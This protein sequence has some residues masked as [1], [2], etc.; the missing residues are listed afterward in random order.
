MAK[1]ITYLIAGLLII[2]GI[3]HSGYSQILFPG[4]TNH[5]WYF[6][7]SVFSISFNKG[8]PA[9]AYLDSVMVTPYSPFGNGVATD[10]VTGELLFYT[11]G[12][13]VYDASHRAMPGAVSR[14]AVAANQGIALS[15]VPG[16]PDQYYIFAINGSG[17]VDFSV[18][19]MQFS[20]NPPAQFGGANLGDVS[21]WRQDMPGN[22]GNNVSEAMMVVPK[23]NL[24]AGYWLITQE[25]NSTIYKV[26]DIGPGGIGTET[27]VNLLS[28]GAVPLTASHFGISPS[29]QIAVAPKEANK[30]IHLLDFD[31]S[32]GSITF[33][34]L[35]L[36]SAT[37]DV[38]AS[39]AIY[40]VE[41][42]VSNF[43]AS[44]TGST[45][46]Q[47]GLFAYD[48]LNPGTTAKQIFPGTIFRSYGL[49]YG[50]DSKI[51]HLYQESS[52]GPLI[53]GRIENPADQVDSLVYTERLY[54]LRN[55]GALQFPAVLPPK[56]ITIPMPTIMSL[57]TCVSDTIWFFPDM[58]PFTDQFQWNFMDTN[59]PAD[60]SAVS[61]GYNY[62]S[63]GGYNVTVTTSVAGNS[64]TG[65]LSIN[66]T[67]TQLQIDLGMDTV[68][69]PND[70][71]LLAI[72][73]QV[74]PQL[75]NVVWSN[76]ET[77]VSSIFVTEGGNYWV[78]G[79][80]S[81]TGCNIN[82]AI[83]VD[84]YGLNI[85][86][87]A[88]WYF[89]NL[90]GLDFN[91]QPPVPLDDGAMTAPEGCA[92]YSDRNGDILFYTDGQTVYNN[93]HQVMPNG[94]NLAAD[95]GAAQSTLIVQFPS[96]ETLYYIFS[97]T[98]TNPLVTCDVFQLSYSVVDLKVAAGG[99]VVIKNKPLFKNSTE[100]ITAV[101]FGN[102]LWLVAHEFG[103]NT[104]RAY[105]VTEFGI[106]AP[107]LSSVGSIHSKHDGT[108]GDG[109]MKLSTDGTRIAVAL[110]STGSNVV[111]LFDFDAS[112][113]IVS[114]ALQLDLNDTSGK[115]YGVE[116]SPNSNWLYATLSNFE[117]GAQ[118]KIYQWHVDSTTLA[119]NVTDTDYIKSSRAIISSGTT[120]EAL[121]A[122]QI[123]PNNAMYVAIN[124]QSFLG[125]INNPDGLQDGT[126]NAFADLTSGQSLAGGTSSALGLPN[127]V[128]NLSTQLP[129]PEIFIPATACAGD[130][131][132]FSATA[133]SIIDE[134]AWSIFDSSGG[135]VGTSTNQGDTITLVIPDTYI[136]SVRIFNRCLDPI[137]FL[138]DS[139][140][141]FPIPLDPFGLNAV[142]ICD[143]VITLTPYNNDQHTE[144]DYL[145]STG[146]T[147]QDIIVSAIGTYS[148]VITNPVAG[149]TN[150]F[151]VFV[152]PPFTV[153][154]G[155]DQ[156]ICDGT[157][158]TLDSQANADNYIWELTVGGTL[159][160]ITGFE[161][162]RFLPLNQLGPPNNPALLPGQ[163]NT[164]TVG[165]VDP[166][167]P[168][169][170]VRDTVE[171][172]INTLP[173]VNVTV[174]DVDTCGV[175]NGKMDIEGSA[176]EDVTYIVTSGTILITNL[177][178][179]GTGPVTIAGLASGVY[180]VTITSS[181]TGCTDS[182]NGIAI[183]E[184]ATF[185]ID[186]T[187]TTNDGCDPLFP[188]G[189]ITF[190][191][192]INAFPLTYT[193]R[194]Q[195]T[196]IAVP[197]H[198][199]VNVPAADDS[200]NFTL[201]NIPTGTYSLDINTA[202]CSAFATDIIVNKLPI[203]D[204]DGPAIVTACDTQVLLSNFFTTT[205]P[206][207]VIE[208]SPDGSAG[209]YQD[210]V[211]VP[212]TT[213]G[214]TDIFIRATNDPLVSCD[215]I[216][217]TQVVLTPQ[218]T[219][220]VVATEDC[221]GFVRLTANPDSYPGASYLY[222][223]FGGGQPTSISAQQSVDIFSNGTDYRVVVSHAVN[224][225]CNVTSAFQT[226]VIPIPFTVQLN[227]TS[228]CTDAEFTVTA[229][230]FRD[231]LTYKWFINGVEQGESLNQ[232]VRE[233]LPGLYRVEASDDKGCTQSD[234]LEII[235]NDP[236][237]SEILPLYTVCFQEVGSLTIDPEA[238]YLSY[239]WI[240]RET[241]LVIDTSP[242]FT[243]DQPGKFQANLVNGFQC[244][245]SDAFDVIEDC[246]AKIIAPNAFHPGSSIE[247]NQTFHL[248]TEF[249]DEFEIFV[250]NRWGELIFHSS[251]KDFNWDG[252]LNG[253]L[254]PVGSYTW[255]VKYTKEFGGKGETLSQFGGITLVQ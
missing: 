239:T 108:M 40:D 115:V 102:I 172:T 17:D 179:A 48:L 134:F 168:V 156:T 180:S 213:L 209:S 246:E 190:V 152:G 25:A 166:V 34:S 22:T 85:T 107:V 153:D 35:I 66:I 76:G 88:I 121:G 18:V 215:S 167:N 51:Y 183:N 77:N 45:I 149:C 250:Y 164:I 83:Q 8:T 26:I 133:T 205:T 202:G 203:T 230:T 243:T 144:Y 137:A 10:E 249:V 171:I 188:S 185:N 211:T 182:Q 128:Q 222:Q 75:Q 186:R 15:P 120:T 43:F 251:E 204:L 123:G 12:S 31:F 136:F 200:T 11:D 50:P 132:N 81:A 127:F 210:A 20:G 71:L 6:G 138:T 174:M 146:E 220:S 178:P 4:F 2:S 224:L 38:S 221:S 242:T 216:R 80:D 96:N 39:E 55:F 129:A 201:V 32:T 131:I 208:W 184:P 199:S 173:A 229:A 130:L 165:V 126:T 194:D 237:P 135:L 253:K 227:S 92:A 70:T 155:V 226:V 105:P 47:A 252:T 196:N 28:A 119:G 103:T 233:N 42:S 212:F 245:T 79:T 21:T 206:G 151:E 27:S 235:I 247:T 100:R 61:P 241:G 90:A 60:Q 192:D 160:P 110:P 53:V 59:F 214:I 228:A 14:P 139:I 89:G 23:A 177:I 3:T 104:F 157:S 36:N 57:G 170:I 63:P 49:R 111:E 95:P 141:V 109:Y 181:V 142:P 86:I 207:A 175:A 217:N 236:T 46:D 218:P 87:A 78:S 225:T 13:T 74:F 159:F 125:T 248:F 82:D 112:S 147:T 99:D 52:G 154:L 41:F 197:N 232:I 191:L 223:W 93:L 16:S 148:L 234:E 58:D 163:I 231:D 219:V 106:G 5:N 97:N 68:I 19:D 44:Q 29:G 56:V 9:Y 176:T 113:G 73:P 140:T 69:C 238:T 1:K 101:S 7:N 150:D 169:C 30:N 64:S 240:N 118:S 143:Q 254:S 189:T 24:A 54:Q 162:S 67:Q 161:S 198:D 122:I 145:W 158:L 116:F 33:N 117:S 193:L 84:E 255:V 114:N 72:D 37:T 244:I 124:G 62:T 91:Q 94:T 187:I 195:I 65:S 98:C